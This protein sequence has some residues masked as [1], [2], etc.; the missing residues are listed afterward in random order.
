MKILKLLQ[1][2]SIKGRALNLGDPFGRVQ[3]EV[4]PDTTL[5]CRLYLSLSDIMILYRLHR[6]NK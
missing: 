1:K 5:R 6:N 4:P 3:G 2:N